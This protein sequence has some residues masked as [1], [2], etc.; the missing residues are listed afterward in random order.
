MNW[1][2]KYLYHQIHPLKLLTDLGAGIL[3]LFPLWQHD[4][5]RAVLIAFIP[6]AFVS[7]LLICFADLE[8]YKAS[9]WGQYI[10]KA[11]TRQMEAV[12]FAGYA[13]M[14]AGAWVHR[15][16]LIPIG[17]VIVLFGWLRGQMFP[18]QAG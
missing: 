14:A 6:P 7:F 17:F 16:W 4:L 10:R 12:R 2:E 3:A 11:M 15:A 1:Q 18:R 8:K 13:V 5:L 9:P